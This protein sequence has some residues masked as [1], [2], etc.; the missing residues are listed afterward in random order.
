[1]DSST[2]FLVIVAILGYGLWAFFQ[3]PGLQSIGK[4]EYMI[5]MNIVV[6]VGITFYLVMIQKFSIALS[7]GLIYPVVGGIAT[8]IA[9]IAFI[10]LAEKSGIGWVTT[11]TS[12]Y[13][14][15]TIILAVLILK[16]QLTFYQ[17]L[18]VV[19]ALI[20]GLLLSL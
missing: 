11:L 15:V 7:K 4:Y 9:S 3:K 19:F 20:A 17:G 16:E 10:S 18:G 14:A 6:L 8:A 13:P 5:V 1:M 2:I 12:L